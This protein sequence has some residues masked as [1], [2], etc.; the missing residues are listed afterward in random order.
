M[1][2]T[3]IAMPLIG[4]IAATR[5]MLGAGIGFLLADKLKREKRRTLGWTLLGIGALSTIPLAL[6]VVKSKR[7]AGGQDAD[8]CVRNVEAEEKGSWA[9]DRGLD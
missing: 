1:K 7:E 6:Q 9:S 8:A 5:G 4:L 3:E 2:K